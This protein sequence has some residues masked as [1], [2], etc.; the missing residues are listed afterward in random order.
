MRPAVLRQGIHG[1][2]IAT[3][4]TI[5]RAD[6][7]LTRQIVSPVLIRLS[8]PPVM[9]PHLLSAFAVKLRDGCRHQPKYGRGAPLLVCK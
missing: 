4:P 1:T 6:L 3:L 5:V 7:F 2:L 8:H 9:K